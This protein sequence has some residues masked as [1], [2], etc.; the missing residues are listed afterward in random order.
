MNVW[1]TVIRFFSAKKVNQL[2][3]QV[4]D[5]IPVYICIYISIY[6]FH[7]VTRVVNIC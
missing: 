6:S 3:L 1:I 7:K 4:E 5:H 2:Q